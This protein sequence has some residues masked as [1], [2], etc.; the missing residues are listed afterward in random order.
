MP[1]SNTFIS[2]YDALP[3]WMRHISDA[4]LV[5]SVD[6]LGPELADCL[7]AG[8]SRNPLLDLPKCCEGNAAIF[9]E[10]LHLCVCEPLKKRP[11]FGNWR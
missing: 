6:Q 2:A 5:C 8:V 10:L 1:I 7:N 3:C 11:D 9:G 4:L